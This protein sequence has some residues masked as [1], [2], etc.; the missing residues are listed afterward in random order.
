MEAHAPATEDM[1]S[2]LDTRVPVVRIS[3]AE[4]VRLEASVFFLFGV[5]VWQQNV[6]FKSF[7]TILK[8]GTS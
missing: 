1:D 4:I 8:F 2:D 5:A 3:W 7:K 6:G